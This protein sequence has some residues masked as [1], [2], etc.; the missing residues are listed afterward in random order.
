MSELIN[1]TKHNME[2][3]MRIQ[4]DESA[5]NIT[6]ACLGCGKRE[7]YAEAQDKGWKFNRHGPAYKAYYCS[8]CAQLE[9]TI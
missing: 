8:T 4:S 5:K 1:R 6:I 7:R 9:V 3:L 2:A